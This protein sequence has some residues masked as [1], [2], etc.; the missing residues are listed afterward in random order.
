MMTPSEYLLVGHITADLTPSGRR[1]GGT[2]SYAARVASAFGLPVKLLTSAQQD[3][4]LLEELQPYVAEMAVLPAA[5]TSTFEN[6]YQ[7][8]RRTQYIRG[9]AAPITAADVP[10]GWQNAPLVHL[11]PLTGEVD[12]QIVHAF[13]D[14][15]VLLTAQGW[16]RQW[17]EDGRVRFKRWFDPDIVRALDVVV[18]SIEDIAEAP[19][20]EPLMAQVAKCL[21]V[22]RGAEGGTYYYQGQ[23]FHYDTLPLEEVDVTGAGD[24]F[25]ASLLSSLRFFNNDLHKAIQVAARLAANSIMRVGL[26]GTPTPD[27]VRDALDTLRAGSSV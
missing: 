27:E 22:T 21:I 14:S 4:P 18:F 16:F 5:A 12:P 26:E 20:L 11:A 13:T 24:V 23:V 25:A 10:A 9:V 15:F 8:G 3:E 6:I 7:Q 1:L 17:G 2:V 19:D